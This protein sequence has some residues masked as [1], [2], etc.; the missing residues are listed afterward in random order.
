MSTLQAIPPAVD[1]Q[2][3][4]QQK[5]NVSYR[6]M[7]ATRPIPQP[8]R[9]DTYRPYPNRTGSWGLEKSSSTRGCL[10]WSFPAG[11]PNTPALTATPRT[12]NGMPC[13]SV[14]A[15]SG[16]LPQDARKHERAVRSAASRGSLRGAEHCTP[17]A[18]S[19][20]MQGAAGRSPSGRGRCRGSQRHRGPCRQSSDALPPVAPTTHDSC[21]CLYKINHVFYRSYCFHVN[22]ST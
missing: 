15:P 5:L 17:A 18:G 14:Q 13:E 2:V 22:K 11:V 21:F 20:V 4:L 9:G 8:P 3:S 7:S 1:P 16:R 6:K 10:L 12:D 19:A